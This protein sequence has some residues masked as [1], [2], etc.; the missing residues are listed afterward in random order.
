MRCDVKYRSEVDPSPSVTMSCF[1]P[2]PL[3]VESI[4]EPCTAHRLHCASSAMERRNPRRIEI[5]QSPLLTVL[6]EEGD[7]ALGEGVREDEL[8]TDNEDLH[9][10]SGIR[11]NRSR[12][13]RSRR[14]E[15]SRKGKILEGQSCRERSCDE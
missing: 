2:S 10:V 4:L 14:E 8:G 3:P 7:Q 1:P 15:Q 13:A 5:V 11:P 12:V 6:A 9:G